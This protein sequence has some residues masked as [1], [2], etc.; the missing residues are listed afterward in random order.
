MGRIVGLV[1]LVA[2]VGYVIV[3]TGPDVV[4]YVRMRRM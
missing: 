1:I 2:V 3:A 4:R